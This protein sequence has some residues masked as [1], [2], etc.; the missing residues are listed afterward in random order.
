M[1]FSPAI[2]THS[3][4]SIEPRPSGIPTLGTWN[5]CDTDLQERQVEAYSYCVL[6]SDSFERLGKAVWVDAEVYRR[7]GGPDGLR[8]LTQLLLPH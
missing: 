4:D 7:V 8:L 3:P 6:M 2:V 5:V 1:Q